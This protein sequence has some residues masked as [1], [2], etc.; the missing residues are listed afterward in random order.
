[1]P[2]FK[3]GKMKANI[4]KTLELDFNNPET[5]KLANEG[6]LIMESNKNTGKIIYKF[7]S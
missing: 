6:H 5:Q 3:E 7:L 4:F 1:M 2:L